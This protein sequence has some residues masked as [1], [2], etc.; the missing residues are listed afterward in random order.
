M[1]GTVKGSEGTN[2]KGRQGRTRFDSQSLKQKSEIKSSGQVFLQT[3]WVLGGTEGT[4]M[5]SEARP[6]QRCVQNQK[7][8]SF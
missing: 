2:M 6:A 7:Q 5:F 3:G 4:A 8:F 1:Q